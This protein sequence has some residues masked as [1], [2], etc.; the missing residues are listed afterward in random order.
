MLAHRYQDLARTITRLIGN[1]TDDLWEVTAEVRSLPEL[2]A[3]LSELKARQRSVNPDTAAYLVHFATVRSQ[4]E[5]SE[6]EQVLRLYG[7]SLATQEELATQDLFSLDGNVIR[8]LSGSSLQ[9]KT[10][11]K[12]ELPV[13][14]WLSEGVP[15]GRESMVEEALT[16]FL[17]RLDI[18]PISA[19]KPRIGSFSQ[20]FKFA[21][22]AGQKYSKRLIANL[23][24]AFGA[25]ADGQKVDLHL[26]LSTILSQSSHSVLSVGDVLAVKTTI[27]GETYVAIAEISPAVKAK[28]ASDPSLLANPKELYW[29]IKERRF[30]V[31]E[32]NSLQSLPDLSGD[33]EPRPHFNVSALGEDKCLV[34]PAGAQGGSPDGEPRRGTS[35]PPPK[36]ASN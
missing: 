17:S 2:L 31:I 15:P 18:T 28:L 36:D 8:K 12:D 29:L 23:H 7:I 4:L 11:F 24:T 13:V 35:Q 21:I 25:T 1:A 14:I 9:L 19:D 3:Y 30:S 22:K 32:S 34:E 26:K 6:M 10:D 33:E 5:Q 27:D 20:A 16:E